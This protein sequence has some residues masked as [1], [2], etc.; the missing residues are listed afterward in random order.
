MKVTIILFML[1][2]I[3]YSCNSMN[4]ESNINKQQSE[5]EIIADSIPPTKIDGLSAMSFK[6]K[7]DNSGRILKSINIYSD[8]ILIQRICA[9]K[10]IQKIQFRLIDWNFDGFKDI[11][12]LANC[13]SGGCS[14]WIW[15]YTPGHKSFVYNK[16]LSDVLGLE[17]DT[18]NQYI[19]FHYRSGY[20]EEKWDSLRYNGEKLFF[21]KG[22]YIEKWNDSLGNSW[23]KKTY[24]KMTN[25][26]LHTKSDSFIYQ[27]QIRHL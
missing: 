5:S 27:S 23:I 18:V 11:T 7:L 26:I 6:F 19:V 2:L 22:L 16:E 4:G 20:S 3:V 25:G 1:V 15:N 17:R 24:S 13:G 21:V 8:K 10:E 14:Y 12:A 9:D